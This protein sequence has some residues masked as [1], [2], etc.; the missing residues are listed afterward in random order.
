[1]V[2]PAVLVS[3]VSLV[4]LAWSGVDEG[5]AVA[6]LVVPVVR[7]VL[8]GVVVAQAVVNRLP[9]VLDVPTPSSQGTASKQTGSR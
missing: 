4:S 5:A 7:V 6:S 3:P 1:M 2:S 8:R 9:S